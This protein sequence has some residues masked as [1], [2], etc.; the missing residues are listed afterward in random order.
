MSTVTQTRVRTDIDDTH[1]KLR[2]FSLVSAFCC[3]LTGSTETKR[4]HWQR[5]LNYKVQINRRGKLVV[6]YMH[7]GRSVGASERDEQEGQ[8]MVT[9]AELQNTNGKIQQLDSCA[10]LTHTHRNTH[11]TAVVVNITV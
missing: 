3:F 4:K 10:A 8:K 11:S 2:G 9:T 1:A 7:R 5:I 6:T